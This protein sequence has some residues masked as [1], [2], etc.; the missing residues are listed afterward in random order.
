MLAT[1]VWVGETL[2]VQEATQIVMMMREAFDKILL[3]EASYNYD[4]YGLVSR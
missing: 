1:L 2:V 3:K 4:N